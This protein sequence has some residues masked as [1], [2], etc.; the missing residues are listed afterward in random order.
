M[1]HIQ[2]GRGDK[3]PKLWPTKTLTPKRWMVVT[4][5][6]DFLRFMPLEKPKWQRRRLGSILKGKTQDKSP[7]QTP[8]REIIKV[9]VWNPRFKEKP[10][11]K[12]TWVEWLFEIGNVTQ[13]FKTD[14]LQ[15]LKSDL[16]FLCAGSNDQIRTLGGFKQII[17]KSPGRSWNR[18]LWLPTHW[19]GWNIQ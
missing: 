13:V 2:D 18:Q 6:K 12:D 17:E 10:Q 7:D 9:S 3:E 1:N 4:P 16:G 5:V 11:I 19:L 8:N 15:R 14:G